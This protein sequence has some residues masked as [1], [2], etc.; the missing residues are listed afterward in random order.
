MDRPA[1]DLIAIMDREEDTAGRETPDRDVET[2]GLLER[3][4]RETTR[5]EMQEK[6]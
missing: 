6:I 3:G 2:T 4:A 1:E 5:A